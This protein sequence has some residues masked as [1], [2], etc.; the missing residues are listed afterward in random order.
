MHCSASSRCFY[1]S[2]PDAGDRLRTGDATLRLDEHI[3]LLQ[4]GAA[5]A[6]IV[7]M[8]AIALATLPAVVRAIPNRSSDYAAGLI[9]AHDSQSLV[10]CRKESVTTS[11]GSEH[12]GMMVGA[13]TVIYAIFLGSST[14]C[15]N[16]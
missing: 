16:A 11:F 1:R 2:I 14:A 13:N 15:F 9:R 12:P 8:L 5:V 4:A 6:A 7:L 10:A 3:T